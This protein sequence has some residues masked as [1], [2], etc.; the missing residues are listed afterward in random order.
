MAVSDNNVTGWSRL[1]GLCCPFF[2]LWRHRMVVQ[3]RHFTSMSIDC[4][5]L[6]IR[7]LSII[8]RHL[9]TPPFP[10]QFVFE[11]SVICTQQCCL[12]YWN[13][14]SI[15]SGTL[16]RKRSLTHCPSSEGWAPKCPIYFVFVCLYF[17]SVVRWI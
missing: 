11:M 14:Y 15:A 6:C 10:G 16:N 9:H 4:L 2:K 5:E 17:M 13:V 3:L 12:N 7:S 8:L 1:F